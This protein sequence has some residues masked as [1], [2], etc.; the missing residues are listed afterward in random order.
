[1]GKFG[2]PDQ[3]VQRD[4]K[5]GARE[6]GLTHPD[7]PGFVRLRDNGDIEIV[8]GEGV[9]ILMNARNR[10]ITFVAENIKFLTKTE[11]GLRWNKMAFNEA[12]SSADEPTFVEADDIDAMS[13]LYFG[14]DYYY[15]L[16]GEEDNEATA[17]RF[18]GEE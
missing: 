13:S 18:L 17:K 1:M 16:D 14:A 9:S 15:E 7:V 8:A 10:S 2:S 4:D 12:A 11:D 5:Y 6:V 3:D